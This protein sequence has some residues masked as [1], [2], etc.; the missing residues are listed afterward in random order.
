M[1]SARKASHESSVKVG[2]RLN[3]PPGRTSARPSRMVDFALAWLPKHSIAIFLLLTTI[4]SLRI[5]STYHVFSHTSDEPAHIAAGLQWL[6]Q[7]IYQYEPQHPPL[8]RVAVALGPYLA[9]LRS[10]NNANM[11]NEGLTLLYGGGHYDRILGLARLG[12]L[13]FF[14]VG[15]LTVYL[16]GKRYLGEPGTAFAVLCFTFLP[17]I[18]AHS[19]LAT[20]DMALAATVSASFL[21]AMIWLDKPG[22][23][24][25]LVLGG[26]M[27]LAVLS[28]FSALVFIPTALAAALIWHL[29]AERPRIS[30][31]LKSSTKYFLPF[32][33]AVLVFLLVIW[34]GYRFSFG[35]V[36]FYSQPPLDPALSFGIQ[37]V[38]SFSLRLPAP[39]LFA[40]IQ[41]VLDHNDLGHEAYLLGEYSQSGWWF[42]YFVVLAV[43]TPL[44]FVGL[45]LCGFLLSDG[46]KSRAVGL[47]LAFSLGILLVASFVSH[48]NIGVRHI[49]PVYMG[50]AIVAGAGA[51]RLLQ[52][53][54]TSNRARW[55]LGGLLFWM[56]GTSAL[57]HPDYLPYFNALAGSEPEQILVDSDLDWGQDMKRLT[58][59]LQELGARE[60]AFTQFFPGDVVAQGLPPVQPF[61]TSTASPGWNA[62]N[63]TALKLRRYDKL[64]DD[65]KSKFWPDE[66]PPTEKIGKGIWL[67]YFPPAATSAPSQV[68]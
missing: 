50:F 39:E 22:P 47:A 64:R 45:L 37:R 53:A 20:T 7:G 44:P 18:L 11:W 59:R 63:I 67:W 8:A 46:R 38:P 15:C 54:Q 55:V 23:V 9:G 14:W 41:Q 1:A 27:G 60:V 6:S 42:Y 12:I 62:A 66:I 49:L 17:P 68:R 43:K 35:E 26:I 51:S 30:R 4:G 10:E 48:I 56:V 3:K 32:C 52:L 61:D 5:I 36:P 24:H 16:W 19:G 2:M 58:Q 40:G 33:G 28:K 21:A 29:V 57:S 13:P 31:L 65:P 34:A 25:S